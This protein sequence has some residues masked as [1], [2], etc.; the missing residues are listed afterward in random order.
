[1][2]IEYIDSIDRNIRRRLFAKR[3]VILSAGPVG[4][5]KLLQLSGIGL[6][7][8]LRRANIPMASVYMIAEYAASIIARRDQWSDTSMCEL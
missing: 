8:V 5:P 4:T 2:R 7:E 1:M 3:E 6:R